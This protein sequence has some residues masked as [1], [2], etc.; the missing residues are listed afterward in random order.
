MAR[1]GCVQDTETGESRRWENRLGFLDSLDLLPLKL[2]D[3]V[4][5]TVA[6]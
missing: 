6:E 3:E 1:W 4:G 2:A 5:S